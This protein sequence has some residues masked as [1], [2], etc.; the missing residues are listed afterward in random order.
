LTRY[1]FSVS[2]TSIR[3][4]GTTSALRHTDGEK[5]RNNSSMSRKGS[6]RA[7]SRNGSIRIKLLAMTASLKSQDYHHKNH[8]GFAFEAYQGV[9]LPPGAAYELIIA[10]E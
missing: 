10:S 2:L 3:M 7:I 1:S 6:N 5:S 8:A 4:R 9:A